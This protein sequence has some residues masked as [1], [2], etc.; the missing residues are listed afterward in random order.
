MPTNG[1][2]SHH[3]LVILFQGAKTESIHLYRERGGEGEGGERWE[4]EREK[5][6]K[7]KEE[8]R[9]KGEISIDI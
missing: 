8:E 1:A 9:E 3:K 7:D 2:G 5:E 6:G 4:R